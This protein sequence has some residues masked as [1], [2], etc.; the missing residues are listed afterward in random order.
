MG[1]PDT[2]CS[3]PK[4]Q[5]RSAACALRSAR[6]PFAQTL[7]CIYRP[8]AG[9]T[10]CIRFASGISAYQIVFC[11]CRLSNLF[12][13]AVIKT[14]TETALNEGNEGGKAHSRTNSES[15]VYPPTNSSRLVLAVNM[16]QSQAL[17]LSSVVQ[18]YAAAVIRMIADLPSVVLTF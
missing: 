18:M 16:K 6:R 2:A 5:R 17:L 14:K 9:I 4:T 12:G 15:F 7:T 13:C 10:D 8:T 1:N 11:S 3:Q